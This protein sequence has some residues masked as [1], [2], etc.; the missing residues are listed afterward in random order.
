MT[1]EQL[2]EFGKLALVTFKE[3]LASYGFKR[4]SKKTEEYF[5]NAVFV[6]DTRYVKILANIHPRDYPPYFNIV[7]GE[8]GRDFFEADWN[9]IPLWRMKESIQNTATTGQYTLEHP[10]DIPRLIELARDELF[11]FA[12]EFLNGD[13]KTFKQARAEQNRSR[14][15][16]RI[17]SPDENGKYTVQDDP[18]S[19]KLKERYS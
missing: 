12:A 3:P 1:R 4:E 15:P 17:Y 19:V 8:G 2:K 7:L 16:Y 18:E 13:L 5:F 14:P 11:E 6:N 9:S 10:E